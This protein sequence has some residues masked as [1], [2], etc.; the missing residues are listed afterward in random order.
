MVQKEGKK[1]GKKQGRGI[2]EK[3]SEKDEEGEKVSRKKIINENY[4]RQET[5]QNE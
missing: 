3:R 2:K 4:H 5:L 1:Q